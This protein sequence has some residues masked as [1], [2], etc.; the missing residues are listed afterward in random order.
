MNT[1]FNDVQKLKEKYK[2]KW[3]S[4]DTDITMLKQY[5]FW[6]KRAIQKQINASINDLLIR[7]DEIPSD[8]KSRQEWKNS[9]KTI[10]RQHAKLFLNIQ[11][12]ELE[13]IMI[14]G[15]TDV[16]EAFIDK[17]REFDK[18]CTVTD[19]V[20][21]IRNV[22]IMNIIQAIANKKIEHT[23]SV[24]AYSMLYPCTDN[25]LDNPDITSDDKRKFNNRLRKRLEGNDIQPES[26]H[27]KQIYD[28]ICMIESQYNRDKYPKVIE[29]IISIHTG[30]CKSLEQQDNIASSNESAILDISI[31]KGGTSVLAD[32]YLVCGDLDEKLSD[33]MFGFGFVLQL[34]DD[35]QDAI[36]DYENNHMTIFSRNVNKTKLDN[37]TN[38]LIAFTLKG[39]DLENYKESP[40]ILD[41]KKLIIDNT[42]LLVFEAVW[43]NRKLYTKKY[44]RNHQ[45]YTPFNYSYL[46]RKMKRVKKK[47][48]KLEGLM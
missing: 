8:D 27:E 28:L 13:N 20:Q 21:A 17:A 14:T 12:D 22:W 46:H 5:S 45:K 16:A 11:N 35:L 23:K 29:S 33:L 38:K 25:F 42:L 3:D 44:K 18:A 31:E 36:E 39:L 37:L 48:K 34:I 30:Q 1:V 4:I 32:A 26:E 9:L 15:F 19:I 24:F 7:M 6:E 2:L 41:I 10:V 43:A 40:Y 47:L